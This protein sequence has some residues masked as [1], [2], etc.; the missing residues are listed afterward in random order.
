MAKTRSRAKPH[1]NLPRDGPD[2][3][4]VAGVGDVVCQ[5]SQGRVTLVSHTRVD[6]TARQ[7]C[8]SLGKAAIMQM[9]RMLFPKPAVKQ[10][11]HPQDTF[12][13]EDGSLRWAKFQDF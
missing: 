11:R 7:Q 1:V 9:L 4:D 13:E 5:Q 3:H 2:A 6:D 12:T 8:S 10:W